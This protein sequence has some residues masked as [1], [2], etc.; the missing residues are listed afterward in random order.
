MNSFN[1]TGNLILFLCA[2]LFISCGAENNGADSE[3]NKNIQYSK[4]KVTLDT[5]FN[6]NFLERIKLLT[7]E[8]DSLSFWDYDT[9][10]NEIYQQW[11]SIAQ[12]NY[13]IEVR[14]IFRTKQQHSFKLTKDT[15]LMLYNQLDLKSVAQVDEQEILNADT[16]ELVFTSQGCFHSVNENMILIKNKTDSSYLLELSINKWRKSIKSTKKNVSVDIIK[17]VVRLQ[18]DLIK[19]KSNNYC[20]STTNTG[21]YLLVNGKVFQFKTLNPEYSKYYMKLK[22]KYLIPDAN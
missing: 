15:S 20:L 10:S 12:G 19:L 9:T 13:T 6:Y 22:K 1:K 21:Y 17:D 4:L 18:N 7:Y 11:D 3:K 5:T 2:I 8:A 16:I 14:T